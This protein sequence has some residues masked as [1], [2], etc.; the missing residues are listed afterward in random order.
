MISTMRPVSL[1]LSIGFALA[2][3]TL[4]RAQCGPD[5]LGTSRVMRVG[6]AGGGGVGLKSYPRTLALADKEIVLTFDDGP[7]PGPTTKVLD[8]LKKECVRATFF[9]IGRNADA[10]PALVRREAAEGHTVAHHTYSHPAVTLRGLSDEA[11]RADIDKGI[12]ADERAAGAGARAPFF[13]FPGFADTKP[14]V[15]WL[16]RRD[17]LVFGT[18]VW[19]SDWTPMSPTQQLAL[20]MGRIEKVRRGIVLFHDTRE[21]T[22]Q[23]MPAFL[24]ELKARGYRIVHIEPGAGR[25]ATVEAG[26]GWRSETDRLISGLMAARRAAAPKATQ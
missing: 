11:A 24:R 21:Q 3:T 6:A 8:A 9:L 17:I 15:D 1:L 23:M 7:L 25:P 2:A 12:A 13:R 20:V 10:N 4:A 5:A 19:A 26:P 22:A 16:A 18:D 14:L